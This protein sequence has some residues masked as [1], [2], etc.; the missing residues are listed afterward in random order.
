[1]LTLSSCSMNDK[2]LSVLGIEIRFPGRQAR[3]FVTVLAEVIRLL[4]SYTVSCHC[5]TNPVS[6]TVSEPCT[7]SDLITLYT[8]L[9][10]KQNKTIFQFLT[11]FVSIIVTSYNT[12]IL[13]RKGNALSCFDELSFMSS[14]IYTRC[15]TFASSM[16]FFLK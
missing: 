15:S 11:Q 2:S 10:R 8:Y 9:D 12:Q 13:A 6:W 7:V 3:N 16:Q 14:I 1:M 5:D 4:H